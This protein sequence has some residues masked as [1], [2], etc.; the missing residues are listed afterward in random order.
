MEHRGIRLEIDICAILVLRW[1][2][3]I[4]CEFAA[5]KSSLTHLSVTIATHFEMSTQGIYS[6]NTH[7]VK[8]DTFLKSLRVELS[9]GVQDT[10]TVD[11]LSLR[12]SSAIVANG[13]TKIILYRY[14]DTVACLHLKLIDRVIEYLL[15]QDVDTIFC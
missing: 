13:D 1:F 6:L 4:A 14:L 12:D 9:A 10:H 2:C 7:S 11:E 15:Q 5:F 3:D 8:S